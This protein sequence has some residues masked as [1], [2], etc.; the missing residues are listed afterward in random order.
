MQTHVEIEAKYDVADDGQLPELIGV[1]GVESVVPQDEMVLTA[2]YFDTVDQSLAAARATLRRRTGGT[3]DGWHLK[4]SL[5]DG[6]RL[7]VHRSLGRSLTP[8]A[9]LTTLVRGFVRTQR[10]EAVATLVNRRTV[11]Q[12]LARDGRVLAELADDSVTG[13]R[14]GDEGATLNWRELE[15]ELVDG[16]RAVL[17]ALD[18]AVRRAGL[19]PAKGA[20]KVGRVL[21]SS[22]LQ[23]AERPTFRRRTPVGD[24]LVAGLREL[25]VDLQAGDP[26][27]RLDRAGAPTR[28][29]A[30]TQRL[31]A[32]LAL[33][34]Q[35]IPDE[36]VPSL[37]SELAWLD[38][39]LAGLDEIDTSGA[40][41]RSALAVQPRELILGPVVRRLDRELAADRRAALAAVREALD[42]ARYL[43]L[44]ESIVAFPSRM[45]PGGAAASR[46]GDVLPDLAERALRRAERR[47]A[48]LGRAPSDDERRWQQRGARRAVQR[49]T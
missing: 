11:H 16:D 29:R 48:Q 30:A 41:I 21:G 49:A 35:V 6:E 2:T 23:F 19:L 37:R 12:L 47:L 42:S 22:P 46:A 38:S 20:S 1:G 27:V 32:A 18:A 13:E 39:V 8:P 25:V 43:D 17:A 33:Q 28:M 44:L 40:R 45:P 26:L 4:L 14:L 36:L 31:R 10:L 5:A 7:E 9:A 15:I 34:R 3:D 24:V